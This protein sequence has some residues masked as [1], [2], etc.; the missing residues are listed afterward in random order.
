MLLWVSQKAEPERRTWVSAGSLCSRCS[1]E[2]AGQEDTPKRVSGWSR[3]W[4]T[5][6]PSP[7]GPLK[8][9][10]NE[11]QSAPSSGG[12]CGI[13]PLTPS[14]LLK[15]APGAQWLG[16]KDPGRKAG[17]LETRG[18]HP[19]SLVGTVPPQLRLQPEGGMGWTL[20]LLQGVQ[21]IPPCTDGG[22]PQARGMDPGPLGRTQHK[23]P[24]I[25][26]PSRVLP[27]DTRV[28]TP[29][30]HSSPPASALSVFF[31]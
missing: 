4:A 6:A 21:T 2:G 18:N 23:G 22:Q 19:V 28:Q 26:L 8:S 27:P 25:P 24:W 20:C 5:G 12:G 9:L 13:H 17:S 29:R 14:P 16:E 11:P 7:W 30:R 10:Q 3:L 1:Q 15:A 31:T